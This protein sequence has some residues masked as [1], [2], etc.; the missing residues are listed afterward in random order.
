[1]RSV[2]LADDGSSGHFCGNSELLLSQNRP[3]IVD[4]EVNV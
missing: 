2:Q 1:M 3:I 4:T